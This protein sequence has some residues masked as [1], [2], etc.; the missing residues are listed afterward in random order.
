MSSNAAQDV[1]NQHEGYHAVQQF[2]ITRDA[3]GFI[4]FAAEVFGATESE[5]SRVPDDD[6]LLIHAEITIGD[7]VI[8]LADRKPDWAYTPAL[9]Q[10]YVRAAQPILDRATR[11]GATIV[12]ELTDFVG[13]L[14][15]ARFRDP[16]GNLWWLFERTGEEF[17]W[18]NWDEDAGADGERKLDYVKTSV[19]E[20]LRT[21][22]QHG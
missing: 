3:R 10:V 13:D 16:F 12:T 15:I 14:K 7:T 17:D 8:M 1:G 5:I 19:F 4:A 2:V 22:A 9:T 21:L 18:E 11:A 6:G 20:E